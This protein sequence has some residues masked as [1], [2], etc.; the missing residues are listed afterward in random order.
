[1]N[2]LGIFFFSQSHSLIHFFSQQQQQKKNFDL[3]TKEKKALPLLYEKGEEFFD[4]RDSQLEQ[5]IVAFIIYYK[6]LCMTL[7]NF[8]LLFFL[9]MRK[10]IDEIFLLLLLI[11]NNKKKRLNDFY[12]L[13]CLIR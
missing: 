1:M 9:Y 5:K 10:F 12:K 2:D 6:S 8:A 3:T 4:Y 13:T 7:R 11:N